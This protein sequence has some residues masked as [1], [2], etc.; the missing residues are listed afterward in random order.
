MANRSD[1]RVFIS[2]SPSISDN[3]LH[4]MLR[5]TIYALS[6]APGKAGVAVV[7]VSG[8]RAKQALTS[9]TASSTRSS[10]RPRQAYFRSIQHPHTRAPLDRGL[11]LWFPGPNS[12]TGEDIVELHV[13]GGNAVVRSVLDALGE[14]PDFRP[15]EQGEFA[16]RA[17]DNDKLDLTELEGLAD[18]LNA[19]TEAQRQLALRQ[20][21]GGLRVPYER[22]RE[23]IIRCMAIMEAVI[24]FG[25]DE[26]IDQGATET[27]IQEVMDM[28]D[29][30]LKH[31]DDKRVGEIVRNGVKVTIVGPPNAGK[32]TLLN[33]LGKSI[34]FFKHIHDAHIM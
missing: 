14:L 33:M 9:C 4:T 1:W 30:I 16:K 32:S 26:Q 20:A 5:Q 17:F 19:E 2:L 21:E 24:D 6:S 31:L 11:V 12:F 29:A 34:F 8:P 25:E 22:W 7:R 18:L 10:W 15:A 27:A 23:Q 13:H 3:L 28:R